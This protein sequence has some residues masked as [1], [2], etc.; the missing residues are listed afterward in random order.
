MADRGKEIFATIVSWGIIITIVA[1]IIAAI[2]FLIE[3]VSIISTGATGLTGVLYLVWNFSNGLFIMIMG[4]I[5]MGVF[6]LVMVFALLIRSGQQF[7]LKLIFKIDAV[8]TGNKKKTTST[9]P[10]SSTSE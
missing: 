2:Y 3:Q 1:I 7:F 9:E 8:A 10:V 6:C 5:I 4:L